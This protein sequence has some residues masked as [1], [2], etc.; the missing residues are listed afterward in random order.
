MSSCCAEYATLRAMRMFVMPFAGIARDPD[1]GLTIAAGLGGVAIEVIRDF[2]MRT[3]PLRQGDALA[4]LSE[5][6]GA[7]LLGA[8][9]GRPAADVV[10]LADALERLGDFAWAHRDRI[11]EI[12]LNPIMV[13]PAGQ[14]CVVADALIVTTE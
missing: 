9:R 12:D 3:L 8:V 6:R 4:M 13:L 11:A 14:G 7:A 10:S 1:W 2:S 5:L